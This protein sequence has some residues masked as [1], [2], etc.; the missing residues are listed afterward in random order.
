MNKPVSV[1]IEADTYLFQYYKSGVITSSACGT[2]L[3]H[4]VV[5]VGYGEDSFAGPYFLVRN[6]WGTWWG[7]Q[8]YVKIG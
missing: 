6:S 8:G 4:A 2:Y 5:A 1:A 7:D 3:D